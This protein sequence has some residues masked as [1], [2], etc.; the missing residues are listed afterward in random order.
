MGVRGGTTPSAACWATGAG[1]SAGAWP[2]VLVRGDSGR[3]GLAGPEDRESAFTRM[4]DVAF[5]LCSVQHTQSTII[6][7]AQGAH[8][9]LVS[10]GAACHGLRP[11]T[12]LH[13]IKHD[14][15]A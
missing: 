11:D 2:A 5:F 6:N 15:Q 9:P 4:K 14:N 1:G 7:G 12:V 8:A 10:L 13:P 3:V